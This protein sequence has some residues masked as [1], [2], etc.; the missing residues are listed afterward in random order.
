[1]NLLTTP[2]N[3]GWLTTELENSCSL[4]GCHRNRLFTSL[5]QGRYAYVQ[6]V[7]LKAYWLD[8]VRVFNPWTL[9]RLKTRLGLATLN[10]REIFP[11]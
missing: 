7:S 4:D 9:L 6:G 11:S 3:N 10:T 1:M 8:L 2:L 5:F